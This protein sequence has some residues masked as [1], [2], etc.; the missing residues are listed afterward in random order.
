[1]KEEFEEVNKNKSKLIF[2]NFSE[3]IVQFKKDL[4]LNSDNVIEIEKT[5]LE[6]Q[7]MTDDIKVI[8]TELKKVFSYPSEILKCIQNDIYYEL[9]DKNL[10]ISSCCSF[11]E[12]IEDFW[13]Y[14]SLHSNICEY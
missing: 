2:M 4:K 5:S 8:K 3:F 13:I 1:M 12:R 9:L 14:I 11:V 10:E 6:I 7:E